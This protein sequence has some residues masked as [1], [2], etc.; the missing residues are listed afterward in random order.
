MQHKATQGEYTGGWAP[1]GRRVAADGSQLEAQPDEEAARAVARQLR[2]RGLS[3]RGVAAG[4]ER[5]GVRSRTGR[6]FA[7]VQVAQDGR[8]KGEAA[9]KAET[10]R[11]RSSKPHA[12]DRIVRFDSG[13]CG[14]QL[15]DPAER[16]TGGHG[17]GRTAERSSRSGMAGSS[18]RC[19]AIAAI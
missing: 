11:S 19:Q 4:L 15:R 14:H 5:R 9:V 16:M 12:S 3:L 1:Y 13:V 8:L 17:S 18:A 10:A 2:A 6:G 7:P